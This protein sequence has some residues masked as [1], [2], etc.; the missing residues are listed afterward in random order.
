MPSGS[1]AIVVHRALEQAVPG[2]RVV[3]Y[4]PW[5]TL[6]PPTLCC[7]SGSGAKLIHTCVDYS[8]FSARPG[9]PLVA[10]FHNYV[11]DTFMKPFSSR[12]Q[13]LHYRTDLR[14]FTKLSLR[15]ADALT[16]VSEATANLVREDL[17]FKGEI[18]VIPN[19][20]DISKF[21]PGG[22]QSR[23]SFTFLFSGNF[24]RRKGATLL[25]A[26]AARLGENQRIVCIGARHVPP[27]ARNSRHIEFRDPV[28]HQRMAELYTSCD[29]LLLPTVR[30]GMSLAAI[31]AM[32][33][34][35]PIVTS[36][37]PSMREIVDDG[38]NGFL[39]PIGDA[40]AFA[41]RLRWLAEHPEQRSAMGTANRARAVAKH[42]S[43]TM[44]DKYRQ[45]FL[46]LAPD[47][48]RSRS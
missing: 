33:C 10:T 18:L 36:D 29:A 21:R 30:E 7:F 41:E 5:W 9:I 3:V 31:E 32:A 44:V 14:L 46:K 8:S 27:W 35:L 20:V 45:L 39:C 15:Y 17:G 28:P 4:N 48:S 38:K 2:Y 13:W 42:D 43:S 6:L 12:L 47:L 25:P 1:G 24:T 40:A 37:C 34:G 19:G 23:S 22:T 11:L 16:A 26:I